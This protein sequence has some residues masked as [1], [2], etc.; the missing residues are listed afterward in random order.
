MLTLHTK[1]PEFMINDRHLVSARKYRPS[2]F[3]TMVG[4]QALTLTLKNAIES[5]RLG[6]AYLFCGPRGVGK[7]SCAR[8]FA[9]TI[10]CMHR[11]ADGEAC[12]QCE[13]CRDFDSGNSYNVIELDAA[14]NNGVDQIRSLT[15]QVNV[16]P[17]IGKY[18]VFIIDEVHM[19]SPAAFNAFLKTLE[20]PPSYAV[21]ILATTEKNKVIPTIL[22]R[23]QIFDF[24]RITIPDI[25][26]HLRMVAASEGVEAEDSALDIIARKSD[27]AMRD[28]LSIF[29][30]IAAASSGKITYHTAI[31][32]LNVLD[33]DYY[34]RFMAFFSSG[35]VAAAMLLFAEV[36]GKGFDPHF[37]LNGL[38]GHI[39]NL[40]VAM[41]PDTISLLD[42]SGSVA[43]RYAQQART[44]RPDWYYKALELLTQCDLDYRASTSKRL[45]VEVALIRLCRLD[46]APEAPAAAS[47]QK[48]KPA[49]SN[50]APASPKPAP[51]VTTP[52]PRQAKT[53]APPASAQRRV[54]LPLHGLRNRE[55]TAQ[56]AKDDNAGS[57]T[58]NTH[59]GRNSQYSEENLRE[60]W[61][62]FI[63]DNQELRILTNAMRGNFPEKI[64]TDT[65]RFYVMNPA[66]RTEGETHLHTICE[67]IREKLD[68]D[69][70][71][72]R[73]EMREI[74]ER[75][76]PL[77]D[78]QLI[79][80]WTKENPALGQF[81]KDYEV[82]IV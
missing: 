21:F 75:E 31:D 30:Q 18:R 39:R 57:D 8:V 2:S 40:M 33:Y 38:A 29:D 12:G 49:A 77:T 45:L 26:R 10:N 68:N 23:C 13:S 20:E 80:K 44:F 37:F 58:D 72:L 9:K 51:A 7:T 69:A 61:L 6:Q 15:E 34:F 56:K 52:L 64:D 50:P 82:E 59:H 48:P 36:V 5:G 43:E 22:S 62:Q 63:T 74:Q 11:G 73:V 46:A 28:A 35:D 19:L 81:L 67:Y 41:S 55:T 47:R 42:A 71:N 17:Q 24:K 70:F 32:N 53:P 65:Y 60:A 79:A 76:R 78:S 16:P 25:V 1:E 66:Q 27:G 4:Q 54:S 3:A 14:S